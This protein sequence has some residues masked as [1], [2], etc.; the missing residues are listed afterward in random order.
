MFYE[1]H[2]TTLIFYAKEKTVLKPEKSTT[3]SVTGW[4][5]SW[6]TITFSLVSLSSL[7]FPSR[8]LLCLFVQVPFMMNE[9][10]CL[11]SNKIYPIIFHNPVCMYVAHAT[12]GFMSHVFIPYFTHVKFY[13]L[14]VLFFDICT[15][16]HPNF[17][18]FLIERTNI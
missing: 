10:M 13:W 3:I 12:V 9:S 1:D 6:H 8:L 11:S 7:S 15:N 18:F 5:Y 4:I 14:W 16:T 2:R 17:T